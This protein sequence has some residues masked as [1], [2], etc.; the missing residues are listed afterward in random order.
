[1]ADVPTYRH[2][3]TGNSALDRMQSVVRDLV[4]TLR[5]IPFLWGGKLVSV[6][7]AS[8]TRKEVRHGLGV[9]ASCIVIRQNYDSSAASYSLVESATRATDEAN[10]LALV[11]DAA[12]SLD[13][14]FYKRASKDIDAGQGQSL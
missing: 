3:Q 8:G 4:A 5:L 12:V 9:A 7:L 11:A 1:M 14:W 2:E 10:Y 6:N 13:L